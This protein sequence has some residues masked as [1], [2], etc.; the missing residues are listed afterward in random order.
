MAEKFVAKLAEFK[1]GDRRIVFVGDNEIGV[2]KHKGEFLRL[3]QFLPPS[4]R[5][6]LRRADHRQGRGALAPGQDLAWVCYFS[7]DRDAFRLPLARHG[8]RH[9]DRRMRLRPQDEAAKYK[10]VQKGDDLYVV[11]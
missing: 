7:E 5:P 4:G 1:D 6:G 3:Q 8:I 10:I 9:E 11:A 2:F